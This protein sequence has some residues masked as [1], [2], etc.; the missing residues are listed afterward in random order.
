MDRFSPSQCT[1]GYPDYPSSVLTP[2]SPP[3]AT[4]K[5]YGI[6]FAIIA[7]STHLLCPSVHFIELELPAATLEEKKRWGMGNAA[8]MPL[9]SPQIPESNEKP[10]NTQRCEPSCLVKSAELSPRSHWSSWWGERPHS[11]V[12][13]NLGFGIRSGLGVPALPLN[14]M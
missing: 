3:G 10:L 13:K 2:A 7:L 6:C 9:A 4:N 1:K 14:T 8:C 5:A 11:E 12:G